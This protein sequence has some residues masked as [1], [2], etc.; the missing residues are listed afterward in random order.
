MHCR[1]ITI[2]IVLATVVYMVAHALLQVASV[3]FMD[4]L[5]FL[6]WL[7]VCKLVCLLI[8]QIIMLSGEPMHTTSKGS[9]SVTRPRYANNRLKMKYL[10]CIFGIYVQSATQQNE[11]RT[12]PKAPL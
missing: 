10:L 11:S 8:L 7:K 6:L 12:V 4:L 2:L 9:N 5:L 1:D 3:L